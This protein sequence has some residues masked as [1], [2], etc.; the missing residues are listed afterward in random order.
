MLPTYLVDR[1]YLS[2]V[3]TDD[4]YC[5]L[6]RDQGGHRKSIAISKKFAKMSSGIQRH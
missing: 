5:I 6:G 4:K 3:V 2:V 1:L